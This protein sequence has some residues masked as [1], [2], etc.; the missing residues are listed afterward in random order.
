MIPDDPQMPPVKA[1]LCL[2]ALL[3]LA[4][5]SSH[6]HALT[7]PEYNTLVHLIYWLWKTLS[8]YALQSMVLRMRVE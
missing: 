7:L 5:S 3:T 1:M 6:P 8:V 2:L 4:E